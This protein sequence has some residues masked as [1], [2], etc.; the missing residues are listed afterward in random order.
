[1]E[2]IIYLATNTVNQKKYVGFASNLVERKKVHF[3][4]AFTRRSP[5]LF[6][7]A[8]RKYGKDAIVWE[9]L[10]RSSDARYLLKERESYYISALHTHYKEGHGYNMTYG[11]DGTLGFKFSSSQRKQL[12]ESHKGYNMPQSQREAIRQAHLGVSKTTEH[13]QKIKK[14]VAKEWIVT[15]PNGLNEKVI[16]LKQFCQDNKLRYT[17]MHRVASGGMKQHRGY[18][19]RRLNET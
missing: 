8:L 18:K 5:L 7:K 17:A 19:C 9:I 16:D 12:S 14:A 11:G 2:Y 13:K 1:M 15:H 4:E 6:H 10:E 3:C